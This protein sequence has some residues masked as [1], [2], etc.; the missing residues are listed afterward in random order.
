MLTDTEVE[1]RDALVAKG[2]PRTGA[3]ALVLAGIRTMECVKHHSLDGI[4]GVHGVGP[5]T[6][7]WVLEQRI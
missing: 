1:W 7:K 6:M 4:Q 2:C 3:N 5:Q